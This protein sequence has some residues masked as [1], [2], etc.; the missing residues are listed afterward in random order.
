VRLRLAPLLAIAACTGRAAPA[1][2]PTASVALPSEP[3]APVR[4][5]DTRVVSLTRGVATPILVGPFEITTINPAGGL[6]L[7]LSA[8]GCADPSAL[9]F[10]YSGGGVVVPAGE[11]LCARSWRDGAVSQAFSGKGP[12]P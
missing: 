12:A 5:Y 9:W 6:E 8:R 1:A 4:S 3:P 11:T 2:A 7:M 10:S